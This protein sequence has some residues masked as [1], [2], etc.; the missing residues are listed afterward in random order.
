[1]I[2]KITS[3]LITILLSV[4]MGTMLFSGVCFAETTS[5]NTQAQP[6]YFAEMTYNNILTGSGSLIRSLQFYVDVNALANK[7]GKT[8]AITT[9]ES[10]V[11]LQSIQAS[12][13]V[14][15]YSTELKDS[16]LDITLEK[17]DSYTDYYIAYDIDGYEKNTSDNK[18]E[19]NGL[20]IDTY[21]VGQTVFADMSSNGL[22]TQYTKLLLIDGISANDVQFIYNYGTKYSTDLI[23][24]NAS[25]IY[26]FENHDA[27]IH[28]FTM[29]INNLDMEYTLI[30]H[31]ANTV[32]WYVIIL[33][34]G[35]VLAG[36][37]AGAMIMHKRSG[38]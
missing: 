18:S 12:Y 17:Y 32:L 3:I 14:R 30:Q 25:K 9:A 7:T 11:V 31:S 21:I 37:L 4:I 24:S 8:V 5:D 35:L 36:A 38:K 15:G 27:Y 28:K 29:D 23:K 13:E 26:Y 6:T 34:I 10:N 33:A 19:N 22:Q 20:F 16:F 2:K 1:M